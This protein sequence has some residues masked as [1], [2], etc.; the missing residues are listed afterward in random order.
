MDAPVINLPTDDNAPASNLPEPT[1]ADIHADLM[2][3]F[4]P[5]LASPRC[6]PFAVERIELKRL[7]TGWLR[8]FVQLRQPVAL[9]YLD[10]IKAQVAEEKCTLNAFV[11]GDRV[12]TFQICDNLEP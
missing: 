12:S 6:M 1:P 10:G 11:K 4:V 5:W 7:Q 8:L 3:N 2:A 9:K